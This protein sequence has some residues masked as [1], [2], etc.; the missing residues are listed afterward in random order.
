VLL[1]WLKLGP[2]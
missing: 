2:V 1:L